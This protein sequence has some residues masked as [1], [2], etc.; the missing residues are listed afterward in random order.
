MYSPP[1]EL[2]TQAEVEATRPSKQKAKRKR[3]QRGIEEAVVQAMTHR[4]GLHTTAPDVMENLP[5]G[6]FNPPL[7]RQQVLTAFNHLAKK[8]VV[9]RVTG[10]V[11]VYR[12]SLDDIAP[13][14][15]IAPPSTQLNSHLYEAI[16]TLSNGTLIV[17]SDDGQLFVALPL[18]EYFNAQS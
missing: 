11:Y 8:G 18:E 12:P 16:G 13:Q 14:P 3:R 9:H 1:A 15:A 7:T 6:Q 10:G 5:K 4:V 17:R 2:P